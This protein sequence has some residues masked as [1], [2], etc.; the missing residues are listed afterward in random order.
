MNYLIEECKYSSNDLNSWIE[1]E[2]G[3]LIDVSKNYIYKIHNGVWTVTQKGMVLDV[4]YSEQ[5]S[6]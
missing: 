5:N 6:L 2:N 4:I 3:N 1:D